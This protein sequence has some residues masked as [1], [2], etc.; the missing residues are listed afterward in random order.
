MNYLTK[1]L[2]AFI[3]MLSFNAEATF[4]NLSFPTVS[5]VSFESIDLEKDLNDPARNLTISA[6]LRV[7]GSCY[8]DENGGSSCPAVILAHSTGGIENVG[9]FYARLL[10]LRGFAT[11][12]I[13]MWSARGLRGGADRP[14]FPTVNIPDAYY[15]LKALASRPEIDPDRIGLM[16]FSWGGSVTMLSATEAYRDLFSTLISAD[17]D[18]LEL[19]DLEFAAFVAHYPVCWAYNEIPSAEF[20]DL[21]GKPLLIQIGSLDDYDRA[22]NAT[23][24]AGDEC[25]DLIASLPPGEGDNVSL[26]V[27]EGAYHLWD[28]LLPAITFFDPF[29]FLGVGG[30]VRIVPNVPLAFESRRKVVNFFKEN[31]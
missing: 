4:P 29:A 11:L 5:Y 16:G 26:N 7:P 19:Q 30:D 24:S 12:E 3:L 9:A 6:Q 27:Y 25:A 20:T 10:N 23:N 17:D 13:D 14:S 8:Q 22:P 31:L 28:R 2:T 15:A 18:P 1:L 21:T